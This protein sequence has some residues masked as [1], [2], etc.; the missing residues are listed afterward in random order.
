MVPSSN[1]QKPEN[2]LKNLS[3]ED[4]LRFLDALEEKGRRERARKSIYVPNSGQLPVHLCDKEVRCVFSG[5]GAGKTAMA[6]NEAIFAVKGYNP[7]SK[8][9][10]PVPCRVVV[11]LDHPEK[12]QD[13]WLPELQKWTNIDK[14]QLSKRG[15]P[16]VTQ[17]TFKNGSEILFMFHQQEPALFESIEV[18]VVICDEPPPRHAYIGLARGG[19]EKGK[20]ARYLMVGTPITGA[21]LRL[22]ILEPW[23]KGELPDTECFTFGTNVNEGNL[24]DGYIERF[25]RKLTDKEKRIRLHGEFFDLEGLALAGLF[26]RDSHVIEHFLWPETWPV[27]IALDPHPS[28]AH[29]ACM[30]GASPDG[31][32]YYLKELRQKCGAREF[33]R[34]LKSW[35][36]GYRVIDIVSDCLGSAENTSGEGFKPFIQ[37]L[38]EEGVPVR[39]TTWTEKNDEDFI[40]RIKDGLALPAEP[41]KNG[42]YIPQL[43]FFSHNVGIIIDVENVQ[44]LKIRNVDMFKP[45]LDITNKDYLSCL[46]YALATNIRYDKIQETVHRVRAKAETYGIKSKPTI[47]NVLSKKRRV[48]SSYRFN[49]RNAEEES[50]ESF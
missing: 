48:M 23:R 18:D 31:H 15:K 10:T 50:W 46:K 42:E 30:V 8:I 5:N 41:N 38:R 11:L 1:C 14:K 36:D 22:E 44:W 21:W 9:Y 40:E 24:A 28:K 33:S 37:V 32:L 43:R 26:N 45:K 20:K 6:V 47:E 16:Y 27:T 4:K 29:Y 3:R 49:R 17:I 34:R 35:Y 19:R 7:V 39:A 13:K 2:R 12:V 25:A